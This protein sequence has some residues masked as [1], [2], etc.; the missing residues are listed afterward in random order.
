M[1][2]F[3][4]TVSNNQNEF[5]VDELKLEKIGTVMFNYLLIKPDIL[6]LSTLKDCDLSNKILSIDILICDDKEIRELNSKYR[7]ID[8]PTDVLSFAIYA[9]CPECKTIPGDMISLGDI[10]ISAQT[11]KRQADENDK[12]FDE[13]INFLLSHGLLH[14]MGFD[15]TNDEELNFMLKIQD[16]MIEYGMNNI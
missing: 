15:H 14:L 12:S 8:K 10:V 2:N 16:E 7:N 1:S 11:T 6:N 4:I 5:Q 13:E 3:C 9:D